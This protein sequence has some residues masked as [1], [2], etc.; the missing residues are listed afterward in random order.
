VN[1]P[2]TERSSRVLALAHEEAARLRHEY[3]GTEHILLG[4]VRESAGPAA[5]ALRSLGVTLDPARSHVERII[6]LGPDKGAPDARGMSPRAQR[7]LG[8]AHNEATQ[9][10]HALVDAEYLLLGITRETHGV[11]AQVLRELGAEPEAV[12]KS[13]LELL[14]GRITGPQ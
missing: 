7:V 9:C 1:D 11:A 6:G 12:R 8:F 2:L 4:I 10:G 14:D 5:L 3:L 13:V